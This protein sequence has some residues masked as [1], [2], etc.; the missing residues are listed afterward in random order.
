MTADDLT[1]ILGDAPAVDA[2][3]L[4]R[5]RRIGGDALVERMVAAFLGHV[6]ARVDEVVHAVEAP[7]AMR[8]AH[9]IKSSAGNLGLTRLALLAAAIEARADMGDAS[10]ATLRP[11][12]G[13]AFAEA[14]A[15]LARATEGSG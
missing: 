7:A 9:A 13:D 10:W 14:R 8:A 1:G 6:P 15:A 11:A 4:A 3:A 5:I 2:Q 12:L